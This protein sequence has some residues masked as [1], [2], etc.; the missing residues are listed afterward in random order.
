MKPTGIEAI[1]WIGGVLMLAAFLG[2]V[3]WV[4]LELVL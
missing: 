3:L 1:V 2:C 4:A